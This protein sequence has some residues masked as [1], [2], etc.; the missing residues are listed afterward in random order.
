MYGCRDRQ[1]A[2]EV[3]EMMM[4]EGMEPVAVVQILESME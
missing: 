1:H 3:M 2:N 4:D